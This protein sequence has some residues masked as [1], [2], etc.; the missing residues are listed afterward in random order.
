MWNADAQQGLATA[1]PH[2]ALAAGDHQAAVQ[3]GLL[4][5][6]RLQ[7]AQRQA[8]LENSLAASLNLYQAGQNLALRHLLNLLIQKYPDAPEPVFNLALL[9]S[10]EGRFKEGLTLLDQVDHTPL[11]TGGGD[12]ETIALSLVNVF[13]VTDFDGDRINSAAL[14]ARIQ[15]AAE[16]AAGHVAPLAAALP[17][18]R[19]VVR[20]QV[21]AAKAVRARTGIKAKKFITDSLLL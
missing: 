8:E 21:L 2:R 20:A 9:E 3:L 1:T 7:W 5:L 18:A 17:A 19:A 13:A 16:R 6:T 12:L 15:L 10:K 4:L 11:A 14:Q